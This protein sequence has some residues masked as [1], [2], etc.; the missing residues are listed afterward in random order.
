MTQQPASK[1]ILAVDVGTKRM[2]VALASSIARIPHPLVTIEAEDEHT[3]IK[4]LSLLI[5]ENDV[6]TVIVGLPRDI[7]GRETNQ[8]HLTREFARKLKEITGV[9][10][11]LQDEAVTSI[12]AEEELKSKRQPYEK[13]DIDKL[14]AALI[15]HDWLAGATVEEL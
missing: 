3:F 11:Y 2:G 10:I 6:D 1:N 13:G 9:K 7:N 14:A 8:T 4:D 5:K 15:L 12:E